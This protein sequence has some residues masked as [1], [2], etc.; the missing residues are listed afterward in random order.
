M[1]LAALAMVVVMLIAQ[2]EVDRQTPVAMDWSQ[3]G[4]SYGEGRAEVAC[5]KEA[6][7][8]YEDCEGRACRAQWGI[9]FARCLE[10]SSALEGR[11]VGVPDIKDKLQTVSWREVY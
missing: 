10:R 2:S 7:N 6:V 4:L 8:H 11:C 5:M 9:F 3:R 1:G